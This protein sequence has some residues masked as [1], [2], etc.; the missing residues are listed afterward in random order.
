MN[1]LNLMLFFLENNETDLDKPAPVKLT[2]Y[3]LWFNKEYVHCLSIQ[4][5]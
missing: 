4:H 2:K 3:C 1:Y 5:Q